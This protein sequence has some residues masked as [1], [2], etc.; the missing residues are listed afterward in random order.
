MGAATDRF[1]S[2]RMVLVGLLIAGTGFVVFSQLH[3]PGLYYAG[4]LLVSIGVSIGGF[5]PSIA[6]VNL[7]MSHRRSAAMSYVLAGGSAGALLVPL[8]AWGFTAFGWRPTLI[9]AGALIAASAPLIAWTMWRRPPGFERAGRRKAARPALGDAEYD[10]TPA[11]ALR[12]RAFW[13]IT[14]AHTLANFSVG[15]VSSQVVLHLQAVGLSLTR[16]S[17]VIPVMGATA[18]AFQLVGGQLGDKMDKRLP[19]SFFLAVQGAAVAVLAFTNGFPMAMAFAVI[20]GVGFGGRT[21]VLHAMRGD[22]FGRR[23]YATIMSLSAVPMALGMTVMPVVA[24]RVFD[25]QH[26]YRWVFVG[27]AA[28]CA[29]GAWVV[30][31]AIKPRPPEQKAEAG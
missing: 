4:W 27:L 6:A 29:V 10:F 3:G 26:T 11:Q 9:A 14:G 25:V 7:W 17:L 5:T 21:P 1:G 23:H 16:A 20:W 8:M 31:F 2:A 18:F 13:A 19:A 15:V 24:G 22:F 12:T 28:A 30:L